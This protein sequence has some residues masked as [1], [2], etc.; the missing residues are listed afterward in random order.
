MVAKI[1]ADSMGV[2]ELEYQL[3]TLRTHEGN[4]NV[5]FKLVSIISNSPG[6]FKNRISCKH[7]VGCQLTNSN[8]NKEMHNKYKIRPVATSM[9]H[10]TQLVLVIN[11]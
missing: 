9:T 1:S 8:C 7:L 10:V 2:S 3:E 6:V 4:Q 5:G 11:R